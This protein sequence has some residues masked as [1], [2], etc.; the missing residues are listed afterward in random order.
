MHYRIWSNTL[1]MGPWEILSTDRFLSGPDF[2]PSIVR[3][4]LFRSFLHPEASLSRKIR[5]ERELRA[6]GFN[7]LILLLSLLLLTLT[8]STS[9]AVSHERVAVQPICVFLMV[10]EDCLLPF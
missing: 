10:R 9:P 2:P 1:L 5:A 7:L 8:C 3:V 6:V 4:H